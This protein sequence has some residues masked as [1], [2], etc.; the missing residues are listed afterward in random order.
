MSPPTV[1]EADGGPKPGLSERTPA[2]EPDRIIRSAERPAASRTNVR[3]FDT[4]AREMKAR[5]RLRFDLL[6]GQPIGSGNISAAARANFQFFPLP[7]FRGVPPQALCCRP[8][9]GLAMIIQK[10]VRYCRLN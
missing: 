4:T 6:A 5:L 2:T 10:H 1:G 3:L 9:R 8:L 7:G